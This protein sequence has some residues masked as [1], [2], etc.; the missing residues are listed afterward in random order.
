[1]GTMVYELGLTLLIVSQMCT[2]FDQLKDCDLQHRIPMLS[3]VGWHTLCTHNIVPYFSSV[4]VLYR[5]WST[6]FTINSEVRD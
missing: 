2:F 3:N 5:V 4:G 6:I 1:M